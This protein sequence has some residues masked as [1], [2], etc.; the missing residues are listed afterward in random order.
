MGVGAT[1]MLSREHRPFSCFR[2][3]QDSTEQW[4]HCC[5]GS[6][7]IILSF[8]D[9]PGMRGFPPESP[10][11]LPRAGSGCRMRAFLLA[12]RRKI[13]YSALRRLFS[14]GG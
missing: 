2:C 10:G 8:H 6:F 1:W 11:L 12:I 3:L 9:A 5:L 7:M 13:W 4:M 14:A